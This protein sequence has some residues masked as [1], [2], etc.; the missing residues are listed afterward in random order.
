MGAP[1]VVV[2][3]PTDNGGRRLWELILSLAEKFGAERE[4]ALVGGLMVQLHG[5]EHDDDPRPTADIDVLGAA[6]KPPRMTEAMAALLIELGAEVADP[7]RSNPKLGYRFEI[8]GEIIELLGP[9]GL[10]ADPKTTA[11]LRTF[12]AAGGTQ[13]LRRTEV[14][15]VS[16]DGNDP[17][18]VRRPNLLGAILIKA[19]VVAKHREDKFASDRQDL[20]RLLGYAEDPRRLAGDMTRKEKGWLRDISDQLAFGDSTLAELFPDRTLERARQAFVLL[21]R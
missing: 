20:I 19:R 9:D 15:L 8:E 12:Q 6:R 5:F 11:G 1:S 4:W 10:R 14:V 7:P 18:A 3:R 2:V 16:L 17:V 21:T 13:A